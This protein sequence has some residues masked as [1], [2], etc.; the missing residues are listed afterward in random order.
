MGKALRDA[1][2]TRAD[3]G[4]RGVEERDGRGRSE[5][6][7]NGAGH[8][9]ANF[10]QKIITASEAIEMVVACQLMVGKARASAAMR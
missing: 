8:A 9:L 5:A 10:A 6:D 1:A 2:E 3:G 4:D 7:E